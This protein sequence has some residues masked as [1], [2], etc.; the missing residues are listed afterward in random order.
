M[1]PSPPPLPILPVVMELV[2]GSAAPFSLDKVLFCISGFLSIIDGSIVKT[3]LDPGMCVKGKKKSIMAHSICYSVYTLRDHYLYR[4]FNVSITIPERSLGGAGRL[5]LLDSKG[6]LTGLCSTGSHLPAVRVFPDSFK[7]PQP[8]VLVQG[9]RQSPA[10][11]SQVVLGWGSSQAGDRG[12]GRAQ[13]SHHSPVPA[14][15]D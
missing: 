13:L 1:Y 2:L 7:K 5:S 4:D 14:V 15:E 3:L 9:R 10:S 11:L 8:T 12:K 6:N